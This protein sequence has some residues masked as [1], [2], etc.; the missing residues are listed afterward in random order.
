MTDAGRGVAVFAGA[1]LVVST[2]GMAVGDIWAA[3]AGYQEMLGREPWRVYRQEP[4]ALAD[5]RYRGEPAEFSFLVAGRRHR[6]ARPS[7]FVSRSK[8]RAC[9]E[10][11]SKKAFPGRTS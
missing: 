10:I 4:P 9:T 8:G 6:A 11:S 1:P 3:M 7:G 2:V 5:M